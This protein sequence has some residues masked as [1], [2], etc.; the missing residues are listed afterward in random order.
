MPNGTHMPQTD[1]NPEKSSTESSS[2][3]I[4]FYTPFELSQRV[5]SIPALTIET[6]EEFVEQPALIGDDVVYTASVT[7]IQE[8]EDELAVEELY[9]VIDN[10]PYW[11]ISTTPDGFKLTCELP[12][13]Y[14]LKLLEKFGV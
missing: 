9:D 2:K 4:R 8:D 7:V 1:T 5:D 10:S 13:Q 11:D 3:P 12:S 14:P 6:F